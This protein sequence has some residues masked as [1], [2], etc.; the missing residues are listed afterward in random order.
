MSYYRTCNLCGAHLDPGERCD[1]IK[2][3]AEMAAGTD[4]NGTEK[5]PTNSIAQ[6][7]KEARKNASI[8]HV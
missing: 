2:E 6:N 8:S 3:K 5:H 7:F 4:H 1:C